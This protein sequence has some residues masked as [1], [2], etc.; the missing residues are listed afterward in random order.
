ML[1]QTELEVR[2]REQLLQTSAATLSNQQL[3]AI[4][5]GTGTKQ[6]PVMMVAAT[7]LSR[8]PN[9]TNLTLA[10]PAE[11]QTVTGV[12][13]T[14]A[15]LLKAA[16]E[17]G[18][19]VCQAATFRYGVIVSS[20]QIGELMIK[21]LAGMTQERLIVLYLDTKNQILLEKTIFT[22]TLNSSVAHPREIM[23][24]ALDVSAARFILVHNHPSG[25]TEPSSY[26]IKFSQRMAHCGQLMGI[27][28]LDHL[29]VG[30]DYLSLKERGDL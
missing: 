25:Q 24:P 14:K 27:E 22:G 17:L 26:D 23:A 6:Q 2:P 20:R 15:V 28:L 16:I 19:R 9:L 29:I 5:L 18:Q 10:T 30:K 13:V 7:L 8:Y 12:G 11:L 4:L 3:L 1:V 21:K